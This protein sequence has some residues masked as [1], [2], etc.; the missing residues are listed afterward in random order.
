MPNLS[1]K[2]PAKRYLSSGKAPVPLGAKGQSTRIARRCVRNRAASRWRFHALS[3]G[4]R[5]LI[6]RMTNDVLDAPNVTFGVPASGSEFNFVFSEVGSHPVGSF[7]Q[8]LGEE[9]DPIS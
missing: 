6:K 1:N 4:R 2:G 7:V 8:P 3:G 5:R 9:I